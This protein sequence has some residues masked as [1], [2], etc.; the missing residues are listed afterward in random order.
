MDPSS[1]PH[2]EVAARLGDAVYAKDAA[3]ILKSQEATGGAVIVGMMHT[4]SNENSQPGRVAA[5]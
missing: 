5:R 4:V 3:G 1:D 2:V